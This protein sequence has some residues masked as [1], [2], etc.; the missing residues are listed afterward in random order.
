MRRSL[1][2]VLLLATT[3][4]AV[5]ISAVGCGFGRAD[6]TGL[7]ISGQSWGWVC[8]SGDAPAGD[9]GCL[10]RDAGPVDDAGPSADGGAD[11]ALP[12]SELRRL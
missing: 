7:P 10:S 8:P 9:A 5:A 6:D 3:A 2:S 4:A 12:S 11:G 1:I